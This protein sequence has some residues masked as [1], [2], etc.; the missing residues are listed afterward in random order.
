[1]SRVV[2]IREKAPNQQ[3]GGNKGVEDINTVLGKKYDEIS[4]MEV[5][6]K[7]EK[8]RKERGWSIN[9]LAMEALLTQST[10]NNLYARKAEPKLSTLRAICNAFGISLAE[11]FA[12]DAEEKKE[13]TLSID[14]E[15]IRYVVYLNKE[16]KTALLVLLK[17]MR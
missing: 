13:E 8:L 10:L 1:M 6:E 4:Y 17:S 14:A 16:Q 15:I 2:Y 11:F 7:I 5:L 3:H 9:N 12:D